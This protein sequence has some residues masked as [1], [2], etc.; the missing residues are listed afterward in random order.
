MLTP[1]RSVFECQELLE[2][3]FA[4]LSTGMVHHED[5]PED[6]KERAAVRSAL[7]NAALVCRQFA[8][9]ALNVLWC[10]LDNLIP[11]LRLV[12]GFQQNEFSTYVR[13]GNVPTNRDTC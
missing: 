5:T 7:A 2:A 10:A 8:E 11:L 12:P 6:V 13:T 4:Q 1:V 9:P 3:I